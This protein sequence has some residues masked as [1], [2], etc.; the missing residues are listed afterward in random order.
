MP[1]FPWQ[2]VTFDI[3]GTLTTVHGWRCIAERFGRLPEF[4]STNRRIDAHEI[5]EDEHLTNLLRIAE[6]RR[7][8]EVESVLEETPRLSGISEAVAALRS[9]G[10]CVALLS[11]NPTYV[12]EWYVRRFG[13]DDFEG[14]SGQSVVD[15]R[16][17]PPG[18][19]HADK[20]AGLRRLLA[21]QG[22]PPRRAA[23]VGDRLS[24]A[25]L[26]PRIGGGIALNSPDPVV[27]QRADRAVDTHDLRGIVPVLIELTPRA[28]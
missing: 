20:L 26:F 17:Q 7:L 28:K 14:T 19:L 25:E 22:L 1:S 9:Q 18:V 6:G 3:D 12:C 24:D 11:H 27:K 21:R 13:F 8:E 23:H 4:E 16:I 10:A 2:L 15:G 5:G